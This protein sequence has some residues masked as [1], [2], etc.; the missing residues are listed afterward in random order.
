[1]IFDPVLAALDV[2]GDTAQQFVRN[3][4]QFKFGNVIDQII[5]PAGRTLG[6]VFSGEGLAV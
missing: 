6:L 3:T 4:V 2:V 5:K 1:M